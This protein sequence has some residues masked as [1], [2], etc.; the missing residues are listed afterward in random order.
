MLTVSSFE[1]NGFTS[2]RING[3]FC[4]ETRSNTL[5]T[6]HVHGP[7]P[8]TRHVHG[9]L[10]GPYAAAVFTARSQPVHD[11]FTA[12]VGQ[13]PL[14]GRVRAMY[15]AADTSRTQPCTQA[16]HTSH[17]RLCTYMF[18]YAGRVHGGV[19][20]PSCTWQVGLHSRVHSPRRHVTA[21]CGP[22]PS[23]TQP[24]HGHVRATCTRPCTRPVHGR[25]RPCNWPIHDRVTWPCTQPVYACTRIHG[26]IR[27]VYTAVYTARRRPCTRL[28]HSRVS[29]VY[30]SRVHV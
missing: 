9:R 14:Q 23:C 29:A 17:T 8:C 21:V 16:V 24:L 5:R 7:C 1:C 28:A 12:R 2:F 22:L 13:P 11:P 4:K 20:G 3:V 30:T 18:V 10:H 6:S 25:F 15:T 26:R 27:A 19:H